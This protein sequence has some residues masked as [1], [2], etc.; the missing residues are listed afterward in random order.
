MAIP[1]TNP[2]RESCSCGIFP[3]EDSRSNISPDIHS[4]ET[5]RT[6]KSRNQSRYCIKIVTNAIK[7]INHLFA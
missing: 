1:I 7:K 3:K 4:H 5:D 6:Y 2:K